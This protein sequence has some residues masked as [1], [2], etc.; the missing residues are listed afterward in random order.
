[1]QAPLP[2]PGG[3]RQKQVDN[4]NLNPGGT[5][6]TYALQRLKRD[7]P[8]L[9][10][11]VIAGELTAHQAAIQAGFRTRMISV[12]VDVE[13]AVAVIGRRP[14]CHAPRLPRMN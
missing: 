3:A 2:K 7:Q 5:S 1:M 9:A 8:E 12:P 14:G 11:K 4:I 6:P 10:E 13:R